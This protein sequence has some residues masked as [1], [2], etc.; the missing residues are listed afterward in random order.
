MSSRWEQQPAARGSL[1]RQ[2]LKR[3]RHGK[4]VIARRHPLTLSLDETAMRALR[5]L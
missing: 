1:E 3:K 2:A 4:S 5:A